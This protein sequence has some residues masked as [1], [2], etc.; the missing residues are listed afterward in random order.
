MQFLFANFTTTLVAG[1]ISS[2]SLTV[3]VQTGSGVLFPHPGVNQYFVGMFTS[4]TIPNLRE[5]V[6]C[7]NITGDTLTIIRQQENTTALAW[8]PGDIFSNEV[9]AGSLNQYVQPYQ[10]QQQL[11]NYAVDAGTTNALVTTL[12]PAPISLAS[13]IGVPIRVK[14]ANTTTIATPTWTT[15]GFGSVT[16]INQN[17]DTL[18]E[19]L[20]AGGIYTLI[21][22]GTNAQVSVGVTGAASLGAVRSSGYERMPQYVGNSAG[23]LRQWWWVALFSGTTP[24]ELFPITFPNTCI[25]M[26]AT[27]GFNIPSTTNAVSVGADPID[28]AHY[29]VT[30]AT[31][32]PT[33]SAAWGVYFTAWGW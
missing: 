31:A 29:S 5:I 7:T 4:A 33:P 26:H 10:L 6:W 3:T 19:P 20:I 32:L 24:N 8:N 25:G 12:S 11:G 27:L 18:N 22:D 14:V 1:A 28:N 30:V 13:L 23:L 15:N 16:L 2:T 17:G 9:T 21:Y